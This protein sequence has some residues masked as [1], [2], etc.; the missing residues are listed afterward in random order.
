MESEVV[1]GDPNFA[2]IEGAD[3]KGGAFF[4]PVLLRCANPLKAK[5]VHETEAFGP[6]ATVMSYDTIEQAI[7]LITM[8]EG[9]LVASVFTYD[10]AAASAL[11]LGIAPYHGRLL[12]I[13]RD[14]GK[15][16]TGHGSPLPGLVHGGPGRAGG[17]E[18]L[19]GMRSVH[20][21]LQRT[22]LQASPQ[23]IAS[24]TAEEM[25]KASA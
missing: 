19:G 6:V 16:S 2:G 11:V 3:L 15:E 10:N 25:S 9:S 14:S 22:A 7:Q 1:F 21:H 12:V 24:I 18:E 23:R 20:H 8:G 13:D 5:R 4:H 17:G